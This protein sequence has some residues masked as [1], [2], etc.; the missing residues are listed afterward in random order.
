MKPKV[1][2]HLWHIFEIPTNNIYCFCLSTWSVTC[3][4]LRNTKT[5]YADRVVLNCWNENC[6][7]IGICHVLL[8]FSYQQFEAIHRNKGLTAPKKERRQIEVTKEN[9]HILQIS[10]KTMGRLKAVDLDRKYRWKMHILKKY[11]LGRSEI[12]LKRVQRSV[13]C[14]SRVFWEAIASGFAPRVKPTT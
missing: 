13:A 14:Q 2:W 5:F 4:G 8:W 10:S 9:D 1:P 6:K 3:N 7:I 12:H 11:L